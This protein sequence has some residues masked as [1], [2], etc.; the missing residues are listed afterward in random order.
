VL[1]VGDIGDGSHKSESNPKKNYVYI[2]VSNINNHIIKSGNIS[3]T[4]FLNE[5]FPQI[6]FVISPTFSALL[7]S[8]A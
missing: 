5:L 2:Y 7:G 3:Q 1:V 8:W 4:S 6:L